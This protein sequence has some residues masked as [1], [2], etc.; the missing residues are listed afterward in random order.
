MNEEHPVEVFLQ[1]K[2]MAVHAGVDERD[3][4]KLTERFLLA[5]ATQNG[6]IARDIA[7]ERGWVGGSTGD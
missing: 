7:E 3:A 2:R 4:E 1:L 5:L 6:E